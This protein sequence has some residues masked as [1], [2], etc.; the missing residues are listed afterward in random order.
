MRYSQY[1]F[2]IENNIKIDQL[3]TFSNY[4]DIFSTYADGIINHLAR[5]GIE[6]RIKIEIKTEF[7][8]Q[9]LQLSILI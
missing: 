2:L 5:A 6:K 7:T 1:H 4:F 8:N 3:R 9:K